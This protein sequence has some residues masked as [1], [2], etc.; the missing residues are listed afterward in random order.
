MVL[1]IIFNRET[2]IERYGAFFLQAQPTIR[3]QQHLYP[4]NVYINNQIHFILKK[5]N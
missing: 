5:L 3:I 2:L 1:F 4:R